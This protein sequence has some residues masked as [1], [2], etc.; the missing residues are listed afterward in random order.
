LKIAALTAMNMLECGV[1]RGKLKTRFKLPQGEHTKQCRAANTA[2]CTCEG[3]AERTCQSCYGSGM[4]SVGP[5]E[6]LKAASEL[7]SYT[8]AKRK[9]IEVIGD[10][11]GGPVGIALIVEFKG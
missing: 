6:R 11:D 4:E 5:A 8:E 1:C 10:G 9:A 3:I 2:E 7:L